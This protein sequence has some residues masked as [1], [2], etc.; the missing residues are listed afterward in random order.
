MTTPEAA[1]QV[2]SQPRPSAP[3]PVTAT[4]EGITS[5]TLLI[6]HQ[7]HTLIA[8]LSAVSK[9]PRQAAQPHP[10]G[11]WHYR[12]STEHN[13][14]GGRRKGAVDGESDINFLLLWYND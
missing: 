4:T 12:P 13:A 14:L 11:R 3:G 9:S 2:K 7:G 5:I 1:A 10:N 6:I 8:Q